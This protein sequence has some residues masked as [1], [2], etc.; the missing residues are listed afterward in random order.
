MAQQV[1]VTTIQKHEYGKS[2]RYRIESIETF[3]PQ[4]ETMKNTALD[5]F[6]QL[7]EDVRG[8]GLCICL[9]LDA[10]VRVETSEETTKQTLSKIKLMEKIIQIKK[11][12]QVSETDVRRIELHT[13]GQSN[14]LK[15]FEACRFC[16][17]ASL[18]G[19]VRQLKP[20]TPP[21]NLVL[22]VLGVKKASLHYG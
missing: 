1:G 9:L 10:S 20:S 12:L 5:I 17:T 13:R 22:T 2:R 7:L 21:D 18:F 8:K 6:P 14:Y 11:Q 15:W 16:L 4:P 19:R 3:D